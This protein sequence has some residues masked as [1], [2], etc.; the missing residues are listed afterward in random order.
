MTLPALFCCCFQSNQNY[1]I[2]RLWNC[3]IFLF[4]WLMIESDNAICYKLMYYYIIGNL[5]YIV[6]SNFV[7]IWFNRTCPISR[8]MVC[9]QLFHEICL[10]KMKTHWFSLHFY[11]LVYISFC[12]LGFDVKQAW[13]SS[14]VRVK[15]ARHGRETWTQ[16]EDARRGRTTRTQDEDVRRGRKTRTQ[17]EDARRGRKTRT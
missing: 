10:S 6:T 16:D 17:D 5:S 9:V 4:T 2:C 13:A 14:G 3:L 15:D 12:F 1:G 8:T 11:L 7:S